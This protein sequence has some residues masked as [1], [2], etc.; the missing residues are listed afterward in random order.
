MRIVLDSA[1][2]DHVARGAPKSN[3]VRPFE[4]CRRFR[5]SRWYIRA[6]RGEILVRRSIPGVIPSMAVALFILV[7]IVRILVVDETVPQG[8]DEPCHIAAGIKWLDQH[9]YTLDAIHPPLARYAVALPL[10]I[11]GERSPK[12]LAQEASLQ[13]YCTE[14]GNAILSD[15]GHY[16][17]NLF[18]ARIGVLPFLCLAAL[19]V[20]FWAT[21]EFGKLAGCMATFLFLSLPSVLAFSSLAYTDSPTMC[22]Q[23]ACIFAFAVWLKKPTAGPTVL[24]G[25][26]AGLALSSKFTSFLFLPLACAA[27]LVV[28]LLFLRYQVADRARE[29]FGIKQAV[30]LVAA[31]CIALV[32]LWASY[33]FSIGHLTEALAES[34]TSALSIRHSFAR[35]GGIF[36]RILSADPVIPAPDLLRGMEIARLKNK[37]EPESYLLGQA[38]SGGW[39]Y[40]FPLAVALKTPLPFSILSIV[41][42][43]YTIR[44][45][46]LGRWSSLMPAVAVAAI[47][48]A[49]VF[50]TLRVGTRHVLVVLPL[51]SVLAGC[52]AA[53]LWQVPGV[54][55]LWGRLALCLLLT[56]QI[57]ASVRAQNDFLAY[58]NE[59]APADPSE[60]LVKGCDLDCGQDVFRLS[61]ELRA[62][63]V[64][65][66]GIGVCTSAD[67]ALID[68]PTL[69][70]L[71]SR[72]PVAGWVAVSLRA[73]KTGAFRIYQNG[74]GSPNEDY[75][76]DAL[77]WLEK[78]RPVA[79]VGKTILL[80]HI[81]E[82]GLED[83]T[84]RSQ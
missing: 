42:L 44:L 63:G 72:K 67:L 3:L 80:Y 45:G 13:G 26:G 11:S 10:F 46:R 18:L 65:R 64:T 43:V 28:R 4:T 36:Q 66:V 49:T 70:I 47:F 19:L 77:S 60:A 39:W 59:L 69:D 83:S 84:Q 74:R 7:A 29:K 12:L 58:F 54:K 56:W 30:P 31:A 16:T 71:P 48:I 41:G 32:L 35:D 82:N 68:L 22:T 50:V 24:L 61:R 20:F 21:Q 75:P 79:H 15:G 37:R 9:D 5:P 17:R 27:M 38:R 76:P 2:D 40:F 73:L 25:I 23:F 81:P 78:Y 14:L 33:A 55:P 51:L 1:I 34:P 8:F 62:R 6:D 53:W 52:G 57:T